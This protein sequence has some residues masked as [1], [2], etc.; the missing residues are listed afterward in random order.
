M[1][2]EDWDEADAV[3]SENI[4]GTPGRDEAKARIRG[5]LARQGYDQAEITSIELSVG[6][7]VQIRL[8]DGSRLF[9]KFWPPNVERS[10]LTAQLHVQSAMASRGFPAPRVRSPLEPLGNGSGVL[11]DFD[12]RGGS[13][14]VRVEGV[15]DAMAHSL[16]RLIRDGGDLMSTPN[17]PQR[18]LPTSLWPAPHNVLFD[19]EKTAE[20]AEW[21]DAVASRNLETL[22]AGAGSQVLGHLDWSAKNMRMEGLSLAVVYDW[23]SIFVADEAD[24]VGSAAA[25]FPITWELV[26]P[27]TPTIEQTLAFVAAYESV[28]ERPFSLDERN[29]VLASASYS[30]CYTARCDHA[31]DPDRARSRWESILGR[32][33][34]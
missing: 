26:V 28:R 4:L 3:L 9:A 20:G 17:L 7:A 13:T 16:A 6:A 22:R 15:S 27:T 23:D 32:L 1:L 19:F 14:D 30:Q 31:V 18:N 34:A 29:R 2:S 12:Q 25:T 24:V 5:W 21:I 11:M 33:T 8:G 10:T